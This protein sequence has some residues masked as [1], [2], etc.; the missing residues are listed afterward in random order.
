MP[1]MPT[2]LTSGVAGL[3]MAGGSSLANAVA[4]ALRKKAV[5]CNGAIATAFWFRVIGAL[6]LLLMWAAYTVLTHGNSG[7]TAPQIAAALGRD[8][9]VAI[10]G[11]RVAAYL[12][13]DVALI[14]MATALYFRAVQ[15][16]S[17]SVTVPMLSFTPV[18]LL[19]A[20]F[21][22][23]REVPTFVQIFG[24][25]LVAGG[26]VLI[27]RG[28]SN[29]QTSN[30]WL[31]SL[32]RLWTALMHDRGSQMMML[33]ALIYSITNPL[34]KELAAYYGPYLYAT[35]Y[36]ATTAMVLLCWQLLRD[37]RQLQLTRQAWPWAGAAGVIDAISLLL[38]FLAFH[39]MPVASTITV[40]RAG[41][42]VTV[43]LGWRFFRE[44]HLASRLAATCIMIL[45]VCLLS[46]SVTWWAV[47]W[48]GVLSLV[49][50]MGQSWLHPRRS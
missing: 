25:M 15:Q 29:G 23:L 36:S 11:R 48:I 37:A 7:P 43:L 26:S 18:F 28:E 20:G 35:I 31:H 42:V 27:H 3:L 46:L 44:T 45:G 22:M 34:D 39:W 19:P 40:K 21:L 24:V 38:L 16:S 13:A 47:L 10:S 49:L 17:L 33:V 9:H 5:A 6:A 8:A 2:L 41:A 50:A 1:E 30:G 14:A 4:D 32:R 12:A